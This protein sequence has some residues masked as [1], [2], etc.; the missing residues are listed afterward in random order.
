MLLSFQLVTC[1]SCLAT[2]VL[3]Y[4]QQT[5]VE[6]HDI[7]KPSKENVFSYS[8]KLNKDCSYDLFNIN[9]DKLVKDNFITVI[10]KESLFFV[11]YFNEILSTY[12]ETA[13]NYTEAEIMD[14]IHPENNKSAKES[15]K[16]LSNLEQFFDSVT[17][18]KA[19][20]K[21]PLVDVNQLFFV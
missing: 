9:I 6:K 18:D 16:R 2:R 5:L 17:I 11:K 7:N 13:D 12:T 14:N 10:E 3:P 15:S 19:A 4:H 8:K 21:A 1:K 20:D